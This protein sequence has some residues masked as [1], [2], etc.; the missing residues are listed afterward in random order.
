MDPFL[1]LL[2][3]AVCLVGSAGM[4]LTESRRGQ[5]IWAV[6]MLTPVFMVVGLAALDLQPPA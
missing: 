3:L 5:Q 4:M 6:V 2:M 1:V